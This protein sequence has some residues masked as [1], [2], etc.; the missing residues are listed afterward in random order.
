MHICL[1]AIN[2]NKMEYEMCRIQSSLS[3]DVT[4]T[5]LYNRIETKKL[6]IFDLSIWETIDVLNF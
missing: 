5:S 1:E 3:G 6:G 2:M 4:S